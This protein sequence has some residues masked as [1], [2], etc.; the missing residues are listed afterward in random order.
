MSPVLCPKHASE[1]AISET[2]KSVRTA[3]NRKQVHTAKRKWN[4]EVILPWNKRAPNQTCHIEELTHTTAKA[5][6]VSAKPNQPKVEWKDFSTRVNGTNY[7]LPTIKEYLLKEYTDVF[8]GIGTLPGGSYYIR[9]K[10]Y[11]LPASTAST[12]L[13]TSEHAKGIQIR[14]K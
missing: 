14:I 8:Q 6:Q 3:S 1:R 4:A 2:S 10:Q 7:S 9:L 13:S 5:A 12:M 11:Y